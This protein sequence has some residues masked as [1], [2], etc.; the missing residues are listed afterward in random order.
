MACSGTPPR[1]ACVTGFRTCRRR[2]L[3]QAKF[4]SILS[5]C[6]YPST[7]NAHPEEEL[8]GHEPEDYLFAYALT[9]K[10]MGLEA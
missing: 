3:P 5:Y 2:Y 1:T 9:K 4:T 7:E 8:Y 6:M 10:A